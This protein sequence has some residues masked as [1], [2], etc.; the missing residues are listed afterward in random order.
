MLAKP[1]EAAGTVFA[2]GGDADVADAVVDGDRAEEVG[3]E[4]TD[5]VVVGGFGVGGVDVAV[6]G[7]VAEDGRGA[8]DR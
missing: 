8:A 5:M 7:E 1:H 4:S 3:D 2:C 6:D